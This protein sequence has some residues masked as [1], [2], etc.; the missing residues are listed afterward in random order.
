MGKK[1]SKENDGKDGAK[2]VK[3]ATMSVTEYGERAIISELIRKL[4][5]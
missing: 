1:A 4:Q 2:I 5:R 3:V